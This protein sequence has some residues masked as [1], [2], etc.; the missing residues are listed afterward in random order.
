MDGLAAGQVSACDWVRVSGWGRVSFQKIS[1][2][3][4]L[5]MKDLLFL[6][7]VMFH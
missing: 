1:L 3:L 7:S 4:V 2:S 6:I 5:S